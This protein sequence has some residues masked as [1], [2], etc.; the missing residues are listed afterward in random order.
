MNNVFVRSGISTSDNHIAAGLKVS[1]L[2][3]GHSG[4]NLTNEF[5]ARRTPVI[6]PRM[7]LKTRSQGRGA[8][9][10]PLLD[11][12]FIFEIAGLKAAL[13]AL[14]LDIFADAIL[15]T[16]AAETLAPI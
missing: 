12:I 10:V 14:N 16:H 15:F 5:A 3:E 1:W 4:N 13:C 6:G 2:I 8:D 11:A 7:C 9:L